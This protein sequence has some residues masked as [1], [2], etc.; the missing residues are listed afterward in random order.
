[1]GTTHML[2]KLHIKI[3]GIEDRF[4][5]F[6]IIEQS[7]IEN[8]FGDDSYRFTPHF[9]GIHMESEDYPDWDVD[10]D[11]AI[12]CVRG[13]ERDEDLNSIYVEDESF[14]KVLRMILEYNQKYNKNTL[15]LRDVVENLAL[16]EKY[17]V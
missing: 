4:V 2:K 17:R 15:E 7:H 1:M 13:C 16:W 3:L 5:E 9:I 11:V 12:L 10:E 14:N 8:A 6:Q